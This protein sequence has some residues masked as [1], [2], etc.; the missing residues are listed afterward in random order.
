VADRT[1]ISGDCLDLILRELR[2]AE[3]GIG[4]RKFFGFGTPFVMIS[5]IDCKLP[6]PQIQLFIVRSGAS[7]VPMASVPWQPAHAA[8]ETIPLGQSAIPI[9]RADVQLLGYDVPGV[10]GIRRRLIHGYGRC[11]SSGFQV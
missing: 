4:C 6:S 9:S 8:L 7:G 11:G 5:V 1:D 3:C 10:L 2:T